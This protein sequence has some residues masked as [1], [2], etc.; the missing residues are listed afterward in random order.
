MGGGAVAGDHMSPISDTTVLTSLAC[1][2]NLM[3]HVNT[4]APYVFWVVLFAVLLGYLP[5]GYGA[6]PN[7]VGILLG[8]VACGLF[9]FF[10]CVP[11]MSPTGSW[12]IVNKLCCGRSEELKELAEDCIKRPAVKRLLPRRL[13]KLLLRS[14]RKSKKKPSW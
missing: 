3:K 4:Q 9:V 14:S 10:I 8:W 12:D 13:K 11:V 5:M 6:Y 1:E 7:I 2:V